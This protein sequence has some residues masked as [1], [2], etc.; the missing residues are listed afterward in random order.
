MTD[1]S[2]F[3][4]KSID[5]LGGVVG[6]YGIA[7]AVAYG[8]VAIELGVAVGVAGKNIVQCVCDVVN[9]EAVG[10]ELR[11]NLAASD[12]VYERDIIDLYYMI[13]SE[14]DESVKID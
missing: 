1:E 2:L 10:K 11:H 13:E 3:P 4:K 12:E 7:E 5:G 9:A 14:A 8:L 6:C